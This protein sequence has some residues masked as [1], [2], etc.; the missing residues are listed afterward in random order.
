MKSAKPC[1]DGDP[2]YYT[3]IGSRETPAD[4]LELM[5]DI[6]GWLASRDWILRSGSAVGADLAFERGCWRA[7]GKAEI[8][9]PWPEYNET[10]RH[11]NMLPP[12]LCQ[13][14]N[15]RILRSPLGPA[16]TIASDH[17]PA[18]HALKAAGCR[19]HARNAHAVL[20]SSLDD[21]SAFLICWT[22]DGATNATTQKT[23]GTGQ[24]IRIANAY[25]VP[26]W[27]LCIDEHRKTWEEVI[28]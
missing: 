6:A 8:Y 18:W 1:F 26:V 13:L 20:G 17:H 23:G 4:V 22:P 10:T 9:L 2:G 27:N 14:K 3:G 28:I 7:E 11:S 19:L 24:A 5:Q 25:N 12:S 15:T 21:P 16:Y